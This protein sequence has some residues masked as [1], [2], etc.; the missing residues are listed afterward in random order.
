[1]QGLGL[2]PMKPLEAQSVKAEKDSG[3]GTK[4]LV[5]GAG[6]AGMVAAYELRAMGFECV[7]LEA[8]SRPGGRNW[9]VRGGD[10]VELTD[11]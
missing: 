10:K 5:L 1:M 4:V 7:V 9:T 2:L 8:K 3:R 6:I 11:G